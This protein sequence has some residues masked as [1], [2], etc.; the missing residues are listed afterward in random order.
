[1]LKDESIQLLTDW[2]RNYYLEVP[3]KSQFT[4]SNTVYVIASKCRRIRMN[5]YS[6]SSLPDRVRV[7]YN[8]LGSNEL[9]RYLQGKSNLFIPLSMELDI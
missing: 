1:M 3:F 5:S 8:Q 7:Y 9:R 6:H 4:E 2:L